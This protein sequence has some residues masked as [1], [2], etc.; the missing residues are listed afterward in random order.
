MSST[1]NLG[2]TSGLTANGRDL[3]GLERFMREL[4]VRPPKP[5]D[6]PALAEIAEAELDRARADGLT[7]HPVLWAGDRAAIRRACAAGC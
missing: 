3:S 4:P 7:G 2:V 6:R 5:S 1:D